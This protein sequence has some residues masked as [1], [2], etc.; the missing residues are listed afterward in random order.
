MPTPA[1][2]AHRRPLGSPTG[3]EP[4]GTPFPPGPRPQQRDNPPTQT[5][6]S[7]PDQ[8]SRE[9][10]PNP[11]QKAFGCPPR[12]LLPPPHLPPPPRGASPFREAAEPRAARRG[13]QGERREPRGG[14]RGNPPLHPGPKTP[15]D[16]P[17]GAARHGPALPNPGPTAPRPALTVAD[18]GDED[19]QASHPIALRHRRHGGERS[20]PPSAAP[21]HRNPTAASPR[22]APQAAA[23]ASA[24]RRRRDGSR[25]TAG[26][27]RRGSDTPWR[28]EA[29]GT[30][31]CPPR[32]P[33]TAPSRPSR[34]PRCRCWGL[35]CGARPVRG[36]REPQGPSA[37]AS[38]SPQERPNPC[39]T[40]CP[41]WF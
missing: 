26:G 27:G 21:K 38:V 20:R 32:V 15:G 10:T 19:G 5:K 29:A 39:L 8:K 3:S 11:Q 23:A 1:P 28:A 18:I 17:A 41:R 22:G 7:R 14:G 24:A 31:P 34:H 16:R 6:S 40:P 2:A 4:P 35:V 13:G 9:L 36:K 37:E 30:R 33:L 25:S 12:A